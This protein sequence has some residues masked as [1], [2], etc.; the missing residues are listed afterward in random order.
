MKPLPITDALPELIDTLRRDGRAVLQAPPGAGKTTLVPLA[1]LRAGLTTGRIIMLEPR[2][3]ATRAAASR[4]AETLGEKLGHTVGYRIRGESKI[5]TDTKIEV[6]TEGILTRMIQSDPSLDGI[7]ALIFD[8]FHERSL[9]A[10]LG[11]A[12]ALECRGAL[13]P[14]LILLVMSATLDAEPVGALMDAQLVTSAGQSYSVKTRWL[15]RPRRRDA[16]LDHDMAALIA[17]AL[18]ETAGNALAFL[19]GEGEIRRVMAKLPRFDALEVLPLYGALPFASQQKAL[20]P[21]QGRRLVLATSIAETSLTLPGIRVV[22]DGGLARRARYNPG[23]GMSRLVTER[24]SR[25]EATQRLGRAGRVSEGVC[26]RLWTKG[27][28]GGLTEFPPAEIET[29]DLTG[30]ALEL[31]EWGSDAL[32]FLTPPPSSA[33]DEAQDLLKALGALDDGG[34][35]N[36]HGKNLARVPLHP[37]LAHMLVSAGTSATPLAALLSDRDP[38]RIAGVDLGKRLELIAT[39]GGGPEVD[40]IRSEAK[41]LQRFAVHGNIPDPSEQA[42]LAY[43]DRIA[44]RRNGNEPRW[45]L[46]GGKGVKMD[47][48]DPLANTRMLVVTETDGHPTEAMIR[49]ALPITEHTVRN[50]FSSRIETVEVA[51][52]SKRDGQVR[53]RKEER[54]GALTLS[55]QRWSDI[56][57]MVLRH[58]ML[59]GVREIGIPSNPAA[60]RLRSRVTLLR[61]AGR[62]LPDMSDQALL[63]SLETWLLPHLVNVRTTNEWY[64]FDLVPALT[65]MMSWDQQSRLDQEAPGKFETPLGRRI[66]IDYDDGTPSIELRLQEMFGTTVHPVIAG[67]PLRVTLLSPAGRPVQ[68]TMDVPGFWTTSYPD[69]RKD[70]RGRYPKH[71]WPEDPTQA[72]PTLKTKRKNEAR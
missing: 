5:G 7:G 11:L 52:W 42:A 20:V 45:L 49:K 6:V 9:N 16:R 37:R 39:C 28:E 48:G 43:P 4:M 18:D 24:V 34:R 63:A 12:L 27:E 72:N 29:A 57:Q 15:N 14:D 32:P 21:G 58:A 19:P 56:P 30:L 47:A 71:P 31:A 66:A 2:R 53:A 62:E 10:D 38:M 8:E 64:K 50:L 25:A 61:S 60:D 36:A 67:S 13:R 35:I 33:L 22:I 41:R 46:S 26:Y 44:L 1:M 70:M 40:R 3:I 55:S 69:V 17:K 51:E 68:T 65:S 23:S 54:L 59:D